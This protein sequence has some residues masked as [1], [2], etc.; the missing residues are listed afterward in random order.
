MKT[1]IYS[2]HGHLEYKII[3]QLLS[4]FFYSLCMRNKIEVVDS[5]HRAVFFSFK[6]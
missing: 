5:P 1:D 3:I 4:N 6:I 2:L